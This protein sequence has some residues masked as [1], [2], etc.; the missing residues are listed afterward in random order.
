MASS[1]YNKWFISGSTA[2]KCPVESFK[3][4]CKK[5]FGKDWYEKYK[6]FHKATFEEHCKMELKLIDNQ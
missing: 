6:L 3:D 5:F 2:I 4:Y 1:D